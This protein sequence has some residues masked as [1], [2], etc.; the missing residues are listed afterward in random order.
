LSL[1]LENARSSETRQ[2]QERL[3]KQNER[4]SAAA[5]I[6]RIVTS[7]LDLDSI[8]GRTVN[9]LSE[10][11]GYN[12]AAV[13]LVDEAGVT[14]NLREATGK[15]GAEMKARGHSLPI[16]PRSLVGRVTA[17]EAAVVNDTMA[18]MSYSRNPLL[19]KPVPAAIRSACRQSHHIGALS[20]RWIAGSF[21]AGIWCSADSRR[22]DPFIAVRPT[23]GPAGCADAR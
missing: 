15:A 1:A 18:D 17:G 5:E 6:G 10:R 2:A 8:F 16:N 9:L 4:L 11:F 23:V 3:L 13:F 7:T 19:P 14:A 20:M 22:P 12:H 21:T